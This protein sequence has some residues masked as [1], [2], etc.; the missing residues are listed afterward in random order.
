MNSRLLDGW[1]RLPAA[2]TIRGWPVPV[3]VA[4]CGVLLGSGVG[5]SAVVQYLTYLSLLVVLP[6]RWVWLGMTSRLGGRG[7][8]RSADELESWLCG[9]AV[10]F[11]LEVV[12]YVGFSAVGARQAFLVAPGLVWVVWGASWIRR[13]YRE[14]QVPLKFGV[15][16]TASTP[17]RLLSNWATAGVVGYLAWWMHDKL[18]SRHPL[19]S[20]RL[21]D[22][23][24]MFQLALVGELRHHFPPEYPFMDYGPL[25]YQWFVHAHLAAETW[26]SGVSA[27]LLYRRFDPLTI[28]IVAVVGA[29][30][31]AVRHCQSPWALPLVPGLLVL[32]GAFDVSGSVIGEAASEERLLQGLVIMH[33]P[34]QTFAYA[35]ALPV[36]ALSLRVVSGD[37]L[38][39]WGWLLL[40]SCMVVLSGAKVTFLPAFVC[41]YLS[42][43]LVSARGSR[44]TVRPAI[45]GGAVAVLIIIW[46]GTVLY[47]GESQSLGLA[48]FQSTRFY[49]ATLGIEGG[50]EIG[51]VLVS[52]SLLG[53]WIT[54]ALGSVGL[55]LDANTRWDSRVWWLL[56]SG[57][58][59]YGATFLLGH[60]GNSQV[61]FGRAVTI[62]LAIASGWG[63]LAM[64]RS[65]SRRIVVSASLVFLVSG[66]ALFLV[67][68][69]TERWRTQVLTDG[70]WAETPVLRLWVNLPVLL[71]LAVSFWLLKI[72]IREASDGRR[73]LPV[74]LLLVALVGSGLAR[75]LA[76]VAN[77]EVDDSRTPPNMVFGQEGRAVAEWLRG[78]SHPDERVATNVHCGPGRPAAGPCDA[79]H[80]WM[81]A[82]SERRFVLEGW[83]Y[84]PRSGEW[85]GPF[86]GDPR[87]LDRNDRV[88]ARPTPERLA[89]F[90]EQYEVTW[91]FID[92]RAPVDE[93]ALR[94][95]PGVQLAV[96]AGSYALYRIDA[97]HP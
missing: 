94:T 85:I 82:I 27:E 90:A 6:G 48:P 25:T 74:R 59:G 67:R 32:V 30:A 79:R 86:W 73:D 53:M 65:A 87:F 66:V 55:L 39:L 45:V 92:R 7:L 3:I 11:G 22:P 91:L 18:F 97:R 62:P 60:V 42:A 80:F 12:S 19:G 47:G 84:T 44:R 54:P 31:V 96:E 20:D 69:A 51:L 9:T 38:G 46:S 70:D 75:S 58:S 81:S 68:L 13:R 14:P 28:S 88:F 16:P 43:V 57:V 56:G 41:G 5:P 8:H 26:G 36:I 34:T 1:L 93:P 29:G 61:Y 64:F 72:V 4:Y 21:V 33:S 52:L 2:A 71:V 63:L 76:F 50:A 10:G 17:T 15:D 37:A 83:A 78:H 77:N 35:L 23:D 49:M 89:S 24:E 40:G 95:L